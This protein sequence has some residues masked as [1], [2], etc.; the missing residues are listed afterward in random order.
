VIVKEVGWG[1]ADDL[2]VRLFD[3]GVAAVDVAGAGG[4]SWSEVERHRMTD[5]VGARVAASFARLGDSDHRGARP[6]A[7]APRRVMC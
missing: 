5:P 3:A 1:I 2:V 7:E 4:T 6:R